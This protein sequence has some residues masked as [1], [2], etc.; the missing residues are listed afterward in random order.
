MINYFKIG[1]IFINLLRYLVVWFLEKEFKKE[2][3]M[4][5]YIILFWI[6]FSGAVYAQGNDELNVQR[7]KL[8]EA[9]TYIDGLY[10][11]DVDNKKIV[12]A[13]I[14]TMLEELD[15]HSTYI[16]KEEVQETN[17]SINGS[18]VGVGIRFQILK[19]TLTVVQTIPGGPSERVGLLAGDKIITVNDENIA[20]IGLKNSGVRKRLLG[21]K[22]SKVNL[23]I[24]RKGKEKPLKFTVTRDVIPL[25]SVDAAYMVTDKTGYIKLNSFSKTSLEEITKAIKELEKRGMKNLILDL[26]SNGGGLLYTARDIADQFLSGD[27]LIVYSEDKW[28]N[29]RNLRA[30]KK[31]LWE[32]G[33]LAILVNEFSAS[34][35]EIVSGAIQD[36]DRG[37]IV[38]RRTFGKGLVQRPLNLSDGSMIRL[39]IARYYTPS[40]RYIQKPYEK[41]KGKDY[42]KDLKKRYE[43]GEFV[44]KDSIQFH[45]SV[46]VYTLIKKRRIHQ[47]GGIMPDVFVPMDTSSLTDYVSGLLQGGHVNSFALDY[48]NE[49]RKNLYKLY[50]NF[51]TFDKNF[52]SEELMDD[53]FEY[54]QKS[55]TSMVFNKEEYQKDKDFLQMRLKAVLAQNLW[56]YEE[57]YRVI[58]K[59]NE[60][61]QRAIEVIESDEYKKI[62]VQE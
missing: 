6:G 50:P 47:G 38:G 40:G 25:H 1:L 41:G 58:N 57:L 2:R 14:V 31:G 51:E 36:W 16:P 53:L 39:T 4:K 18:F 13:A 11:D 27:K 26:Q 23:L 45:D 62:G 5:K 22:G 44:N 7:Q 3:M 20:G 54:A 17:Q 43:R 10:V 59:E 32:K 24:L 46:A 19:D 60:V 52:N 30:G 48:V 49:N 21:E 56:G 29:R 35:S 9:I 8:T 61:L 34:A 28:K 42:D 37:V 15:P 12:D 55:D 33:R